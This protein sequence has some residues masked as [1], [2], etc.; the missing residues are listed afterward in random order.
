[1]G[2]HST[3]RT[4]PNFTK[5]ALTAQALAS[6]GY[7]IASGGGPGIMEAANF[8]AYMAN[9]TPQDLLTALEMMTDAPHYTDENYHDLAVSV[10]NRYDNG[11]DNLAIPTWFYGHEPSNVFAS[12]SF[13]V[14]R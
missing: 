4:D 9:Y 10:L 13:F 3:K 2:G 5:A 7:F 6:D 12:Q 11:N 14:G 1:M 8:G